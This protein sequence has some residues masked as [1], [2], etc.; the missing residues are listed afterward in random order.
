MRACAATAIRSRRSKG[1]WLPVVVG[2]ASL[3]LLVA[4]GLAGAALLV[5]AVRGAQARIDVAAPGVRAA[6][7]AV[8]PGNESSSGPSVS[9]DGRFVAIDSAASNLSSGEL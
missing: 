8:V 5:S 4:L 7:L 3:L 1:R 2:S 6:L 9:A